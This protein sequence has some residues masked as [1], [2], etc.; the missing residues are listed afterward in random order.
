MKLRSARWVQGT[1][2]LR[3][4]IQGES[5]ETSATNAADGVANSMFGI[6]NGCGF[7]GKDRLERARA[8]QRQRRHGAS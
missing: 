8:G 6:L 4:S 7:R 1:L 5:E 2:P 3:I